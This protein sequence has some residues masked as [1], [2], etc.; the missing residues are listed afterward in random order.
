MKRKWLI[1]YISLGVITLAASIPMLV[2]AAQDTSILDSQEIAASLELSE[3]TRSEYVEGS[4]FD[5]TG[6][7]FFY[8]GKE[9][10]MED[11]KVEYDFSASGTRL[12][13]FSVTEGKKTYVAKMPVSVYHIS[14]IDVRNNN[15]F[16]KGTDEWDYSRL[17]VYAEVVGQPSSYV[18]PNPLYPHVVELKNNDYTVSL[19]ETEL[20][21]KYNAEIN[22]GKNKESIVCYNESKFSSRRVVSFYNTSQSGESLTLYVDYNTADFVFPDGNSDIYTGGT[23]VYVDK[24]E[25]RYCY[26]FA[27]HLKPGWNNE[28]NC[29]IETSILEDGGLLATINGTG[30]TAIQ[31][32]WHSAVLGNAD[33]LEKYT[34]SFDSNGG[35]GTMADATNIRGSYTLPECTFTAPDGMLFAGW[36]VGGVIYDAGNKI[37]VYSDTTIKAIWSDTPVVDPDRIITFTND[38]GTDETLTLY[39][40]SS[41]GD[42]PFVLDFCTGD[43]ESVTGSYLYVNA[44]GD[45][46]YYPF[47]FS[48]DNW[49]ADFGSNTDDVYDRLDGSD[50]L[51]ATVDGVTFSTSSWRGA[52]IGKE[53]TTT[54]LDKQIA[55]SNPRIAKMTA[56]EPEKNYG[57]YLFVLNTD[58]PGGFHWPGGGYEVNVTGK[59]YFVDETTKDIIRSYNFKYRL[60]A[61]WGSHAESNGANTGDYVISDDFNVSGHSGELFTAV[62]LQ[63]D[64]WDHWANFYLAD[65]AWKLAVLGN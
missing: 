22:A 47:A 64:S 11:V 55:A 34:V 6:I 5:T 23:Y 36:E 54:Y 2:W 48:L 32:D 41:T 18:V 62:R 8:K 38:A 9:A 30:F 43:I 21:G 17:L 49:E 24:E 19:N 25:N 59:Y 33:D 57:M 13:K 14:H 31:S 1:T 51:I 61:Y 28:F 12:V 60:D 44:S 7:K 4:T 50:N 35:T 65:A 46:T 3:D 53:I 45:R 37:N 56:N 39:V 15:V 26:S 52:I 27:Y 29:Q 10:N 40:E 58:N 16:N 20:P 42:Y 63:P